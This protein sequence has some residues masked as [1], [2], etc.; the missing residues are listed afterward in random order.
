M[1]Q[2][3][4][5]KKYLK[6]KK[7]YKNERHT[8]FMLLNTN[9]QVRCRLC[10]CVCVCVCVRACVCLCVCVFVSVCVSVCVERAA[11]LLHDV[12]SQPPGKV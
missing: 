10:V 12:Q 6:R 3:V 5:Q 7:E 4:D 9:P 11:H 2:V 1:H 8:Y